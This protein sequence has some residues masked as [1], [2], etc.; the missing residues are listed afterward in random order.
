MSITDKTP[1]L[2]SNDI[3]EGRKTKLW[4]FRELLALG[5]VILLLVAAS[6]AE[7]PSAAAPAP[8]PDVTA[9][10]PEL[11][12]GQHTRLDIIKKRDADITAAF[13]IWRYI[14]KK[15]KK[16]ILPVLL[17]A[18]LLAAACNTQPQ[19]ANPSPSASSAAPSAESSVPLETP[20]VS[21]SE[22]PMTSP[23]EEL[24]VFT[25]ENFPVMDGS[26]STVPLGQAVASVLLG[27]PR[28]QVASLAQFNKTTQSFRNLMNGDADI[29]IV[30]EPNASVFEEMKKAGF[31]Y[32]MTPFANDAL[33]FVVNAS[34]P[35]DNLTTEQL[36][37]I[38][39]GEITNWKQVGGADMK[40]EAFQRNAEAGSQ[41]LMIKHVM[42]DLKMMEPP[43]GYTVGEMEGLISAVKSFD[44]SASAIGYTVYYYAD[45]MKMAEGLKILSI[46]GV[47]PN[48]DTIAA[49]EYP[50]LNPYYVV[51]AAKEPEKSPARIMYDWL[52]SPEGQHLVGL[53][54]Y[55]AVGSR[56]PA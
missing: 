3:T 50:F 48:D 18:L 5:I 31:K 43:Q 45:D 40:I 54:G 27:E 7:A 13:T 47:Q 32:E 44:G 1:W 38:Y 14:M 25:R 28:D 17:L 35:V 21:P 29:L 56:N 36:Q 20:S 55:V 53:E 15:I 23:S 11:P 49:K 37:K 34:N 16:L 39:T 33:V 46:D 41:S 4:K 51:I 19:A 52:L 6:C 42:K 10:V 24:F 26:T 9:H 12:S 2:K 8:P 30:G 22:T